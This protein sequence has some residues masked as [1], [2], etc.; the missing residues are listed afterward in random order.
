L[1]SIGGFVRRRSG[2]AYRKSAKAKS[3]KHGGKEG[4]ELKAV[5][6]PG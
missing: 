1:S 2:L 3:L 6:F 5:C 4:T